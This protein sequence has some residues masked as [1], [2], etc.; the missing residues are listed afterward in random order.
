MIRNSTKSHV[1]Y[2]T[3]LFMKHN[4]AKREVDNTERTGSELLDLTRVIEGKLLR[5]RETK[6]AVRPRR[7]RR[8]QRYAKYVQRTSVWLSNA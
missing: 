1:L 2:T 4:Y 5:S 6:N 3:T 7:A 8:R